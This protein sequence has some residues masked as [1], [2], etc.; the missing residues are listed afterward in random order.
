ME[1]RDDRYQSEQSASGGAGD[2]GHRLASLT[3]DQHTHAPSALVLQGGSQQTP[4]TVRQDLY[5]RLTSRKF[6]LTIGTVVGMLIAWARDALPPQT[7]ALVILVVTSV[8]LLAEALV[9]ANTA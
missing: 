8:Y 3:A 6:L 1:K 5:G 9:D 4:V 2:L 7:S